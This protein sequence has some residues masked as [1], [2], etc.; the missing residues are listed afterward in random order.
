MVSGTEGEIYRQHSPG[1]TVGNRSQSDDFRKKQFTHAQTS[2]P[3]RALNV[4]T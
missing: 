2:L 1:I 3:E 4:Q